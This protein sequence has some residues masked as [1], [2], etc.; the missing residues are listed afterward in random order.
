MAGA[1]PTPS[2]IG[3]AGWRVLACGLVLWLAGCADRTPVVLGFMGDLTGRAADLGVGGRDAAT[4]AI[5]EA[6]AAGGLRGRPIELLSQDDRQN[7]EAARAAYQ[8]FQAAGVE[9]VIGPMTSAVMVDLQPLADQGPLLLLSPT[10][11]SSAFDGQDDR[12]FRVIASTRDYARKSARFHAE[13]QGLRRVAV[14]MD[15]N[16]LAFTQR[17]LDDFQVEFVRLGGR[18]VSRVS[19]DLQAMPSFG[20][21]VA[22]ALAGQPDGLLVLA[23]AADAALLVQ[24]VRKQAP[25]V[26]VLSSEWSASEAFLALAGRAAEGV[27]QSQFFDRDSREPSYVGF[28]ARFRHRFG[29]E[30]G[31]AEVG[32][33]DATRVALQA[34]AARRDGEDLKQ[35]LLRV[36]RFEG[37]QQPVVFNPTGDAQRQTYI[38]VVRDG[39][40]VVEP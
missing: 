12:L 3:S 23:N 24:Q 27:H 26:P 16:N 39:R 7:A 6:N 15:E 32:A 40:Y 5:E 18:I 1:T 38:T 28:V 21:V 2:R 30:P 29:R 31:F 25:T 34:L 36:G 19:F 10:V 14:V 37:V 11:T 13:R 8:A 20:Q 4:L 22:G 9:L 33:Y 35:T 17:W